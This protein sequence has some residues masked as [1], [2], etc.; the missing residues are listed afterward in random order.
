M[1]SCWGLRCPGIFTAA[2]DVWTYSP[3]TE[4][5]TCLDIYW[6]PKCPGKFS[7]AQAVRTQQ[8]QKMSGH[9]LLGPKMSRH[10][11]WGLVT[12]ALQ[13]EMSRHSHWA[14]KC[15]DIFTGGPRCL[16]TFSESQDV[17]VIHWVQR[18]L[19]FHWEARCP[20]IM[21]P[22]MFG[23]ICWALRC[24]GIVTGAQAVLTYSLKVQGI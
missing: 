13:P 18:C 4:L 23:H 10:I 2:Q 3:G 12:Y 1:H 11:Y 24:P 8:A 22:K 21:G 20:R 16:D 5:S 14:P 7:G 9:I 6:E 17:W 19:D 15:M